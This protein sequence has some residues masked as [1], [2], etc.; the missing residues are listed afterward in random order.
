M[1]LPPHLGRGRTMQVAEWDTCV[2][3][4]STGLMR[5]TRRKA[6]CSVPR[7]ATWAQYL[8]LSFEED[9]ETSEPIDV[10]SAGRKHGKGGRGKADGE[11]AECGGKRHGKQHAKGVQPDGPTGGSGRA[12]QSAGSACSRT[13]A[14]PTANDDDKHPHAKHT[15]QLTSKCWMASGFPLSLHQLLPLLEAIGTANK[16]IARV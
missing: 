16:P 1:P 14:A 11:G 3:E 8:L 6:P 12:C 4:A 2:Y 13:A 5:V 7:G 15:R 10:F 9:D